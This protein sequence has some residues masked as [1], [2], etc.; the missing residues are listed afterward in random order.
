LEIRQLR[1]FLA[2]VDFANLGRAAE[3]LGITTPAISKSLANLEAELGA[4]LVDRGPKGVSPTVFGIS[5]ARHARALLAEV[6]HA[7]DDIELLQGAGQGRIAVGGAASAGSTLLVRAIAALSSDRPGVRIEVTGGRH[8]ALIDDLRNGVLDVVVTGFG[9]GPADPGLHERVLAED[10]YAVVVRGEHPL[11]R[12]RNI[13]LEELMHY[14][15]VVASN[16]AEVVPGWVREFTDQGLTPPN[17]AISS[18]SYLFIKSIL[19]EGDFISVLPRDIV[20]A[21]EDGRAFAI[22]NI[23]GIGWRRRVRAVT[24][25]RGTRPPAVGFFWKRLRRLQPKSRRFCERTGYEI[26]TPQSVQ[27]LLR[28]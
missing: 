19:G 8:E 22:L 11:S 26:E 21:T 16:I 12:R 6:R 20:S 15:W 14:P 25:A 9:A 24:R 28:H 4:R 2:A 18:D 5:L 10:T 7:R 1:Q 27:G 3:S 23:D 13:R 17:P